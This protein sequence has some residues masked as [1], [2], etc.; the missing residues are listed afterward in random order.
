MIWGLLAFDLGL[1]IKLLPCLRSR[2]SRWSLA[3]LA[4]VA[5]LALVVL[6]IDLT[7]Y[8]RP[9]ARLKVVVPDRIYISAMPTRQGLELA[10]ERHHFR[11]II[12]LFPEETPQRS[13]LLGEELAFIR[14]HGIQYVASPSDSSV[15]VSEAFLNQTLALAQDPSAWPILVHCHGCMDRS[16]AWMGIYRFVVQ[17]RSLLEIMQ[18]IE[19]HRGYRPK[20]SVTLL[21]NRVLAPRAGERYW[22][23]P[24]ATLLR[25]CAEGTADPMRRRQQVATGPG[26]EP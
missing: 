17:G 12:N 20:A 10:Q 26:E 15:A 8:H 14:T 16:P 9:L 19:R 24:T 23:D 6:G 21:Y 18:E 1:L 22:A 3:T 11:T 13:P 5:W 7:W 2:R 4:P 25:R